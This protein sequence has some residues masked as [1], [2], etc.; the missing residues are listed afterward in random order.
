MYWEKRCSVLFVSVM[1]GLVFSQVTAIAQ[2]DEAERLIYLAKAI[3]RIAVK[4]INKG[5]Q[6]DQKSFEV[7][8]YDKDGKEVNVSSEQANKLF[9]WLTKDSSG[10]SVDQKGVI[11][12][13]TDKTGK[14]K[15]VLKLVTNSTQKAAKLEVR[16]A[17]Q[18]SAYSSAVG[19]SSIAM[20]KGGFGVFKSIGSWI[21]NHP[22]ITAAGGAVA[23]GGTLVVANNHGD[24]SSGG[25]GGSTETAATETVSATTS[26]SSS[27]GSSKS[28]S[29]KSDWEGLWY[30]QK[31]YDYPGSGSYYDGLLF[32]MTL[33]QN[34]SQLTGTTSEG[35]TVQGMVDGNTFWLCIDG[36]WYHGTRSGTSMTG[37]K[38]QPMYVLRIYAYRPF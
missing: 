35:D 28:D 15:N 5:D 17:N 26:G 18:F 1:A 33:V 9:N 29:S 3:K 12:S 30:V 21:G 23:V 34:G 27:G 19:K 24:G 36:D 37:T 10:A 6:G 25:G 7:K 8:A 14:A 31:Y 16:L 38:D 20:G 32:T 22:Y 4:Q 13:V 11:E 2:L